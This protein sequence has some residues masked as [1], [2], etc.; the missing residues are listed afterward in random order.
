MEALPSDPDYVY[1]KST[2]RIQRRPILRGENAK[3]TFDSIPVIDV[4]RIFSDDLQSR[5]ALA[6]QIG[7]AAK[8]VGFFCL[9]NPPVSAE[10]MGMRS[11]VPDPQCLD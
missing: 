9:T 10:K 7:Q 6:E 11:S 3:P 2:D 1:F 8:D 5:K 4:S